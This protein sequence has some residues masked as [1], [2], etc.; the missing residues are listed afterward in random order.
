MRLV[1]DS[2]GSSAAAGLNR[3]NGRGIYSTIGR[4]VLLSGL[5]NVTNTVEKG[6]HSQSIADAVV[7]GRQEVKKVGDKK[8]P[9]TRPHIA[10]VKRKSSI[11]QH[12]PSKTRKYLHSTSDLA[13][14]QVTGV[15]RKSSIAAEQQATKARKYSDSTLDKL[16]NSSVGSGQVLD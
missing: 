8:K 5:W 6:N 14:P 4:K 2:R 3:Y 10:G 16:I 15:K 12:Q 13:I 7:N 11:S 1:I 9:T